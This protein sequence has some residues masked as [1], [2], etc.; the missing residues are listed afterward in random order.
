MKKWLAFALLVAVCCTLTGC[1]NYREIDSLSI[2]AGVAIER[3]PESGGGYI[4]Y[5]EIIEPSGN[6]KEQSTKSK[7]VESR[8]KTIFDAARNAIDTSGKRLFWNHAQIIIVSEEIAKQGIFDVLDWFYRDA[9]PRLTL[10]LLV[11]NGASAKDIITSDGITNEIRSLEIYNKIKN[12]DSVEMF[13]RVE[14]YQ[15]IGMLKFDAPYAYAPSIIIKK[16]GDLKVS[17]ISGIAI[18]K[19]DKLR[20]FLDSEDTKYF[21]YA[22]NEIQGGLLICDSIQGV[23]DSNVSLEVFS[24]KT[25]VR[26]V[27]SNG[28]VTMVIQMETE[29]AVGESGSNVNYKDKVGMA[30]LKNDAQEFLVQNVMR[31]IRKVQ[32][33][34]DTDIFGF[35]QK[36][37]EDL[38]DVWKQYKNRW[39]TGFKE[40]GFEISSEIKIR[41]TAQSGESIERAE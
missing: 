6:S 3:D 34:F 26:P 28:K 25:A 19:G 38:P 7:V 35:G 4:L 40:L 16:Q 15:L 37:Y 41:N 31:V 12:A 9:E 36:I 14:L 39:D 1:W 10:C 29:V 23:P 8:G 32:D 11:A 24:N 2:V 30:S 13:P 17:E 22:I 5:I 33:E 18:F 20:G 21:L 27:Y